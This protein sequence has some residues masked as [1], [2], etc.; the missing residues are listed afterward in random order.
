[1]LRWIGERIALVDPLPERQLPELLDPEDLAKDLGDSDLIERC[2]QGFRKLKEIIPYLR[3]A[4]TRFAHPGRRL[5]VAGNPSWTE[6]VEKNLGVSVRRVQ[7]L[8]REALEP[9]ETVSRGSKNKWGRKLRTGDWRGLVKVTE[10]R[11][12]QVFGPLE[13]EELARAIREF[14]QA[15]ADRYARQSGRITVSVSLKAAS[16]TRSPL[17]LTASK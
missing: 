5:P 10:G 1:V 3:E 9:S 2:V 8:L 17:P 11:T 16:G 13:D 4:R 7:Q 12:A 14:A 15:I 6:W